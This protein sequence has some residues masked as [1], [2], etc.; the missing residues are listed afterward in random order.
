MT[1]RDYCK[2]EN[3]TDA[4]VRKAFKSGALK[5]AMVHDQSMV[6]IETDEVEIYKEKNRKLR[7]DNKRLMELQKI[8]EAQ[9]KE[10]NELKQENKELNEELKATLREAKN[11]QRELQQKFYDIINLRI[12]NN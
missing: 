6:V 2:Q 7:A 4:A 9:L 8:Q 11:D 5:L 3:I 1:V 10:M 12:E